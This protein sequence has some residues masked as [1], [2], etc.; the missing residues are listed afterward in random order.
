MDKKEKARKFSIQYKIM[1]TTTLIIA[2]VGAVLAFI[3]LKSMKS[4]SQQILLDTLRPMAKTASQAVE[5]NLHVLGDR[6]LMAADHEVLRNP[7]S[8]KESRYAVMEHLEAGIEFVWIGLYGNDGV[9]LDGVNECPD[10]IAEETFFS[11]MQETG[12]LVIDDTAVRSNGLEI[13]MGAPVLDVDGKVLYYLVGSY[14]YDVM[15]DVL[16]NINIGATGRAVIVNESGTVM[17]AADQ[18][19]VMKEAELSDCLG[20]H[21]EVDRLQKKMI[22]GEIGAVVLGKNREAMI[23]SYA[24]VRGTNWSM[25]VYVYQSDFMSIVND[26]ISFGFF[27][28]VVMVVL[29][30]LIMLRF[31]ATISKPLRSITS[32]IERLAEGDLKTGVE[33]VKSRDETGILSAALKETI[34]KVSSYITELGMVLEELAKGNFDINTEA[35][36]QG[37]FVAMKQSLDYISGSF[38]MIMRQIKDSVGMLTE[39]SRLVCDN[40][41][42]VDQSSQEQARS[43]TQLSES[44][45]TISRNIQEVSDNTLE[46]R[47]LMDASEQRLDSGTEL[48]QKLLATMEKIKENFDQITRINKFL[49]DIAFQTNILSL[50]AAVEASR[51]GEAGK[52]FAVV[53]QQVR[54]LAGKT[55]ES[56]QAASEI[57]EKS[58]VSV[59][60]GAE[61]AGK[62]AGSMT[63]IADISRRVSEITDKLSASV[64]EEQESLSEILE[65]IQSIS[66]LAERNTAVSVQSLDASSK[67]AGQAEN[68]KGL[69][70]RFTLRK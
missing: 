55:A 28:M 66:E 69:A 58:R 70:S 6:I 31:A 52:G 45:R 41:R 50:N 10:S 15:D 3:M 32:R 5:S 22:S 44:S 35:E 67:L 21:Q 25:A 9:Y 1:L 26:S 8:D 29:A 48:M 63:E 54:D 39:T 46:A 20:G 64:E 68:L 30:A 57:I 62:T 43:V 53:A 13:A 16:S 49:S 59:K 2:V 38:N 12:N 60:E 23:V 37:D 42:L 61:L 17:A 34:E 51:A 65:E 40:S 33:V 18:S 4:L 24:P 56:A 11:L 14:Q 7:Q 27:V 19:L 36:F 47:S